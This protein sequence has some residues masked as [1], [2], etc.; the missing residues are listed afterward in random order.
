MRQ[1]L[2]DSRSTALQSPKEATQYDQQCHTLVITLE[3]AACLPGSSNPLKIEP[4]HISLNPNDERGKGS[5]L[6]VLSK[7]YP[8]LTQ[9]YIIA[10]AARYHPESGTWR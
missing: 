1:F 2:K 6:T 7:A 4:P 8:A 9:G 10:G 3:S 5:P